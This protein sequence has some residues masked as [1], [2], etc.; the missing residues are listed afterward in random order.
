MLVVH[1]NRWFYRRYKIHLAEYTGDASDCFL[2]S[3][4]TR[5]INGM[6]FSTI[7][8][9]HGANLNCPNPHGAGWRYNSCAYGEANGAGM[10]FRWFYNATGGMMLQT[11]RMMVKPVVK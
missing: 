4:T 2:I 11:S 5:D 7:D 8:N 3:G 6:A 10:Y 1:F 9:S